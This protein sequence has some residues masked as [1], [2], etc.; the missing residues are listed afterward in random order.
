MRRTLVWRPLRHRELEVYSLCYVFWLTFWRCSASVECGDSQP[1]PG[2]TRFSRFM[3]AAPIFISKRVQ[4]L[5]AKAGH[6]L[7][8]YP[9]GGRG[10]FRQGIIE[11]EFLPF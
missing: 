9:W 3:L 6:C 5:V 4:S 7:L 2:L 10:R 8:G 1:G 11:S